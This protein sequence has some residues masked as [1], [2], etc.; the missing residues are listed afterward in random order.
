VPRAITVGSTTNTDAQSS[1]S[2]FGPCL[3]IYA[4]GSNIISASHTSNT[5]ATTLSGT[6]MAAPH[7]AGA[8]ALVLG[9]NG[10][11]TPDQARDT[12]VGNATINAITGLNSTSPNALL[13]VGN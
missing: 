1:F 4:P 9:L 13:F 5:G 2:S 10:N 12:V 6:S 3:D 8:V 11:L 7:V